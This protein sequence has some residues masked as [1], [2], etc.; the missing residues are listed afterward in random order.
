LLLEEEEFLLVETQ[1]IDSWEKIV[2]IKVNLLYQASLDF[3][4]AVFF[5]GHCQL[6]WQNK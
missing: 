1:L 4:I 3:T 2:V 6:S 5:K